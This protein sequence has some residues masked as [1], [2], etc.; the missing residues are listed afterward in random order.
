MY[1]LEFD[2]EPVVKRHCPR[3]EFVPDAGPH[4]LAGIECGIFFLMAFW[5]GPSLSALKALARTLDQLDAGKR[6]RLVVGDTDR[7]VD[8][9]DR[10]PFVNSIGGWG[11]TSWIKDGRIVAHLD[12]GSDVDSLEAN[13]RQLLP[14]CRDGD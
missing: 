5:S 9:H 2:G 13:T 14:Q 7:L 12:R 8:L 6:L 11:E 1:P 4:T 10:L 3:A